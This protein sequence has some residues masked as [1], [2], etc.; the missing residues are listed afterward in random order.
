MRDFKAMKRQR[1]RNRGG[2][3]GNKPQ[4]NANRSF[5]SNGPENIKVRGAAPH[6]LERYQQLAR[7]AATSGD[8]VLAENFLQHAEHYYRTVRILQPQRPAS[9][10]VARDPFAP[11]FDFDME[12]TE[13]GEAPEGADATQQPTEEPRQGDRYEREPRREFRD[14]DNREFRDRDNREARGDRYQRDDREPRGD[15][16]ERDRGEYRP[17]REPRNEQARGEG[18]FRQSREPRGDRFDRPRDDR[19]PPRE[20]RGDRFDRNEESRRDERSRDD[21]PRDDRPR[22]DRFERAEGEGRP[23]RRERERE[24]RDDRG[25]R[26]SGRYG[27][28]REAVNG[29]DDGGVL[30]SQDGG[31]SELPG[32]LQAAVPVPAPE[33]VIAATEEAARP[34]R[35]RARKPKADADPAIASETEEA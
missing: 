10:F 11:A 28:P 5:E 34:K 12:E 18:D 23:P 35:T 21:R 4:Q 15:R 16:Y 30:R 1:G 24:Y 9:D 19:Y 32:F 14:R 13:A 2:S 6:V 33:P 31:V 17:D 29:A 20:G 3:G 7:D 22:E 26:P 27:D 25:P 8:R